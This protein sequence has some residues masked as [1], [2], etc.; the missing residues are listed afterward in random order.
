[1][2]IFSPAG[3]VMACHRLAPPGAGSIIRTPEQRA[4]LEKVVLGQFSTAR[5]CDRKANKPPGTAALAERAKLLGAGGAE[6]SVDLAGLAEVIRLAF[7]GS[8]DV[9]G[10]GVPA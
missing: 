7:P 9:C 8:T 4:A 6:P 2:E 5:P 10:A 3:V 1:V